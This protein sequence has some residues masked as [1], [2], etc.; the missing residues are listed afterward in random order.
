[1]NDKMIKKFEC[2][3][4]ERDSL[5]EALAGRMEVNKR[6]REDKEIEN[7]DE[8]AYHEQV[9]EGGLTTST[10]VKWIRMQLG[11]DKNSSNWSRLKMDQVMIPGLR[12]KFLQSIP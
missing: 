3:G 12:R 10:E 2:E 9:S 6:G 8:T 4:R 5:K 11:T 1:M 7:V